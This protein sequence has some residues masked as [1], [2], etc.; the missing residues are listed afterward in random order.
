MTEAEILNRKENDR[1]RIQ[2]RSQVTESEIQ[3]RRESDRLWKQNRIYNYIVSE[4]SKEMLKSQK[5]NR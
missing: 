1:L 5:M 3:T 4:Q 2:A